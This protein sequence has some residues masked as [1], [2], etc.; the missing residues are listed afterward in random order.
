MMARYAFAYNSLILQNAVDVSA[1]KARSGA[2]PQRS[3]GPA[4]GDLQD[5]GFELT[6]RVTT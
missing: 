4:S 5:R 3:E 6:S 2:G 1:E